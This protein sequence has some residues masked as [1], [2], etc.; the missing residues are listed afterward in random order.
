MKSMMIENKGISGME[1]DGEC[2]MSDKPMYPYGLKI[3]ID[4]ESY[5]KLGLT[6]PPAVGSGFAM[7]ARV[8]V[9]SVR[10]EKTK[11][12]GVEIYL[13]LQITDMELAEAKADKNPEDV[14]YTK[15]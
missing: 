7:M 9:C 10:Q 3:S 8:E 5:E 15:A 6:S 4:N 12:E 14:L 1:K 11:D 13:E 2:C